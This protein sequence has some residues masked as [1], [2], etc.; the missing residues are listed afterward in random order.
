MNH[1]WA[2]LI[3]KRVEYTTA[4]KNLL[5]KAGETDPAVLNKEGTCVSKVDVVSTKQKMAIVR[6][7]WNRKQNPEY[8]EQTHIL[9]DIR[10]E[11]VPSWWLRPVRRRKI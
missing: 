7:I 4:Y 6:V 9:P 3:G 1:N 5:I 8:P 11:E 2:I 10:I